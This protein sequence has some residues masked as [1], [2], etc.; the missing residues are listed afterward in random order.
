MPIINIITMIIKYI[1]LCT[2]VRAHSKFA[3]V[4]FEAETL[5]LG[6]RLIGSFTFSSKALYI[7]RRFTVARLSI[8]CACCSDC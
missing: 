6:L 1:Y 7:E 3:P 2:I 8:L 5:S 4:T